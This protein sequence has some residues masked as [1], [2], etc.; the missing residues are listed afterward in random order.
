MIKLLNLI[1]ECYRLLRQL[2]YLTFEAESIF[3]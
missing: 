2:N 3:K 1:L